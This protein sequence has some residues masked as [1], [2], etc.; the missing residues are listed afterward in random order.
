MRKATLENLKKGQK[1]IKRGDKKLLKRDSRKM[2]TLKV[3]IWKGIS[4]FFH[5]LKK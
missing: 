2:W 5:K 3:C 1:L 4:S